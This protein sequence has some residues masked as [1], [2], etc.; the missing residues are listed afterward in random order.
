[1]CFHSTQNDSSIFFDR[2]D[3][4]NKDDPNWKCF[5]KFEISSEERAVALTSG[6]QK[7][8]I[9]QNGCKRIDMDTLRLTNMRSNYQF[10][11]SPD[12]VHPVILS[13]NFSATQADPPGLVVPQAD[14]PWRKIS[15]VSFEPLNPAYCRW[16]VK[17]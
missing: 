2:I 10:R 8:Q 6:L 1:M 7:S 16:R 11:Q 17:C 5:A 9:W 12:P 15:L 4:I 3:R 13:K 14:P